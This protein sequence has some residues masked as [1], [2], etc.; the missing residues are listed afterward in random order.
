MRQLI[1]ACVLI[2]LAVCATAHAESLQVFYAL[3]N[4]PPP[5]VQTVTVDESTVEIAAI[6]P[7]ADPREACGG[8]CVWFENAAGGAEV[9]MIL[10]SARDRSSRDRTV[11]F[12]RDAADLAAIKA[13]LH[14]VLLISK[15]V[16]GEAQFEPGAI[17]LDATAG[18]VE[19]AAVVAAPKGREPAGISVA[20]QTGASFIGTDLSLN[21]VVLESSYR[22]GGRFFADLAL[23]Y[24]IPSRFTLSNTLFSAGGMAARAGV[25]IVGL[26]TDRVEIRAMAGPQATWYEIYRGDEHGKWVTHWYGW[27][28][29][30]F[31]VRVWGPVSLGARGDVCLA[32]SDVVV[33]VQ[34]A[35]GEKRLQ[36]PFFD[37][38]AGVSA[39]F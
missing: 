29:A 25:G 3:E 37:A 2:A 30:A 18:T 7:G 1:A 33:S 13:N 20:L 28:G 15:S 22:F 16:F 24:L 4:A 10:F 35:E 11:A 36:N 32:G 9:H 34:G 23:I 26:K 5:D 39:A 17:P 6:A 8:L 19:K 12:V 14:K 31:D 38:L 27:A 21:T